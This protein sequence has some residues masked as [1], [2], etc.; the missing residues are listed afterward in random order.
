MTK[1]SAII[2]LCVLFFITM[3]MGSCVRIDLDAPEVRPGHPIISEIGG[4]SDHTMYYFLT[5]KAGGQNQS[6]ILDTGSDL[7]GFP[8][9]HTCTDESCGNH[10]NPIYDKDS[11]EPLINTIQNPMENSRLYLPKIAQNQIE[12]GIPA[13]IKS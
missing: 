1:S 11:K 13:P 3:E 12:M 4:N 5:V 6:V 8:C 2:G 7:M 9:K 10:E